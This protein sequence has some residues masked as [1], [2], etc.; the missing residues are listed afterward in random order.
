MFGPMMGGAHGAAMTISMVL[1]GALLL[2]AL[3]LAVTTI[4]WL[5]HR[6]V[7]ARAGEVTSHG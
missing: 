5:V 2:A 4:V 1:G 7:T 6:M 3:V